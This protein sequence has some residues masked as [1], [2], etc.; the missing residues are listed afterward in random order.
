MSS[1]FKAYDIRGVY[2]TEINEEMVYKIGRA[3]VVFLKAKTIAVGRDARVSSPALFESFTKGVMDQGCNV[4]DLGVISTP[5]VYYASGTLK[6]DGA[7]SLTASHNPQQYNG[8]KINRAS[9]VPVGQDSGMKD[10]EKLVGQNAFEDVAQ[11]GMMTKHNIANEYMDHFASFAKLGDKKLKVVIDF[12]NGTGVLEFPLFKKFSENLEIVPIC[13]TL[14]MSFPNHEANP[15]KAETLKMLQKK[16]LEEK[17]DI[18]ISFDGDADRAGFV[19][20]NAKIIPM[21]YITGMIAEIVLERE[22]GA[23]IL[24]DLRST[25]AVK[26]IIEENGGKAEECRV[27]HAFIKKQ[28]REKGAVFAGELSGHY[29]FKENFTA[30]SASFAALLLLN[31]LAET[32]QP[33]SEL[34]RKMHKYF[35]SGEINSEVENKEEIIKTLEETYKDGKLDLLDGIKIV[36]PTWWFSVRGSNTEPLLRLNV[37]ADTK[38]QM[39]EKRDELLKIIRG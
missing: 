32:G 30:E 3:T 21:D 12:G 26:E 1:I 13:E 23:T 31:L 9:A 11:K 35:Q 14:D 36:Y 18:G 38:E 33:L 7:I 8:L 10:I 37:E 25:R 4:I 16:V 17:A 29:Y 39:E 24:Y 20:E 34:T 15:L 19:D 6:V 28:M 27:G 22:K 5:M 2:P